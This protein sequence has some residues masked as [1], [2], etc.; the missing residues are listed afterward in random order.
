VT[1]ESLSDDEARVRLEP[2]LLKLYDQTSIG[3]K[4]GFDDYRHLFETQWQDRAGAAGWSLAIDYDHAKC[5]FR[6]NAR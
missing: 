5:T 3:Q 2:G 1:L 4:I 6:F